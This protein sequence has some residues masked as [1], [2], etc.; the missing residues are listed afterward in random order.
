[1]LGAQRV[2]LNGLA[3]E[4]TGRL[5]AS[6]TRRRLT[7]ARVRQIHAR[8]DGNPF[9]VTEIAR[10]DTRDVLGIPENVRMAISTRINRL[11]ESARQSLVVGAV[12]GREFDFPLLRAVQPDVQEEIL[13]QALDAGL[14]AL[15]IEPL[16]SRGKDWYQF[17]HALLRDA[18][19][20]SIS[21]SRRARWHATIAHT[22]ETLL[23]DGVENRAAE[24]AHHAASAGALIE[25]A[26]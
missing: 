16:A 4:G 26:V 13:L 20:E 21:P 12:I 2:A 25:P 10:L 1:R 7:R 24:L 9:F 8:T 23:G 5:M 14:K 6:L 22:L 11:S 18:V 19:Y 15:V 3:L 17:R